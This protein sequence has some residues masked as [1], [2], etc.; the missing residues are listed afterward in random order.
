MLFKINAL[1]LRSKETV[2]FNGKMFVF[3]QERIMRLF[4]LALYQ[5]LKEKRK[6]IHNSRYYFIGSQSRS[7]QR[8]E[9]RK[10]NQ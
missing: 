4:S 7:I 1:I 2:F 5:F 3:L 6:L 8:S 9:F 10:Q